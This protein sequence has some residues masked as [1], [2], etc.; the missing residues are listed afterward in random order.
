M[1]I[2]DVVDQGVWKS[3]LIWVVYGLGKRKKR[4]KEEKEEERKEKK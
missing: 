1:E 3:Q 4:I 2:W